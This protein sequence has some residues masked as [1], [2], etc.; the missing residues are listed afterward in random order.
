VEGKNLRGLQLLGQCATQLVGGFWN[1]IGSGSDLL[2]ILLQL[3][4]FE[5]LDILFIGP[6]EGYYHCIGYYCSN[7]HPILDI[8]G[9]FFQISR[10]LVTRI[11]LLSK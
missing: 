3:L 11:Y 6:L 10:S 7:M 4:A 8:I 1:Y 2:G 5:G 9:V